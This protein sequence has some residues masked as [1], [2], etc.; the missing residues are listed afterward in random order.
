MKRGA[1][2]C[3]AAC[4]PALSTVRSFC[5]LSLPEIGEGHARQGLVE[6]GVILTFIAIL[7]IVALVFLCGQ[8]ST[9]VSRIGNSLNK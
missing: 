8:I 5:G 2:D 6:Y 3:G 4:P 9:L 7:V 1:L